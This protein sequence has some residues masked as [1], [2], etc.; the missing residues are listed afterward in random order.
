[1]CIRDSFEIACI[2]RWFVIRNFLR[3]FNLESCVYLDSDIMAYSNFTEEVKKFAH[4]DA[5]IMYPDHQPEYRWGASGHN[6]YWTVSALADFCDFILKLYTTE[7]GLQKLVE[8]WNHHWQ[9][10]LPGGVCDM[11][12]LHLFYNDPTPRRIVNLSMVTEGATY[13]D[14]LNSSENHKQEEY[15]L[16]PGPDYVYKIL[17]DSGPPPH[18][19]T[20][21]DLSESIFKEIKWE[22]GIP[23]CF[24]IKEDAW[25]RFNTLHFQGNFGKIYLRHLADS[26][27]GKE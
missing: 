27:K 10:E 12:L 19:W 5:A 24:N 3:R 6:S 22:D 14:N 25:V 1:M 2:A 9:H 16:A 26:S 23:Y 13:D 7:E 20:T 15:R 17:E 11:S 4:A 18:D 8:K 21:V